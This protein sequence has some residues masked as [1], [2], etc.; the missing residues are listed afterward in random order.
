M[1]ESGIFYGWVLDPILSSVRKRA[2]VEIAP[3]E[4]VID[5]ACGTGAQLFEIAA[6]TD[7]VVG[8]DLSGAMIAYAKK[9]ATKNG[10]SNAEFVISDAANLSAFED[11]SFDVAMLSLALH[12]FPPHLHAPVL[13]EMK[14]VAR[15][16]IIVDYAVPLPK[17]YVGTGSR[18][19]EFFA[20][21]EHHR[22]FKEYYKMGG[23]DAILAAHKLEIKKSK[24]LAKGAFR[25]VVCE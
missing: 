4:T 17:N 16:I 12:Q 14:R 25:L 8:V 22:N 10:V 20:G 13:N 6:K 19:A 24:Q 11:N 1:V 5:I 23:L 2:A 7:R 9:R 3:H 21:R 15:K 18:V